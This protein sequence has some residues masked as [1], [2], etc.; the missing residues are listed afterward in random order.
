MIQLS[1]DPILDIGN[2]FKPD[3]TSTSSTI[4]HSKQA[5]MNKTIFI[6]ALIF[7]VFV[8]FG[9]MEHKLNSIGLKTETIE[10]DKKS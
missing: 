6:V 8:I 10:S 5:S 2:E 3:T 4:A 7:I 1:N 9:I